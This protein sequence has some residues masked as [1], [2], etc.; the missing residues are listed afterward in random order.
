MAITEERK[1]GSTWEWLNSAG[2]TSDNK[3]FYEEG[4]PLLPDIRSSEMYA[5]AVPAIPPALAI[6][7]DNGIVKRVR[8]ALTLDNSVPNRRAWVAVNPWQSGWSS[9]SFDIEQIMNQ[10]L[11]KKDGPGYL[12]KIFGGSNGATE[13]PPL[14]SSSPVFYPRAGILTF[15]A[16]RAEA[17]TAETSSIWIEGYIYI[18]K[19]Q[20]DIAGGLDVGDADFVA[21]YEAGKVAE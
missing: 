4:L 12:P 5:E 16:S 15:G 10:W 21:T 17:G 6:G 20:S 8:M 13:I 18:G 3:E 14:D 11:S 19:M 2:N 1:L 9:G 7:E